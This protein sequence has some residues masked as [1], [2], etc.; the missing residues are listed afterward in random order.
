M[1]SEKML[2]GVQSEQANTLRVR[3]WIEYERIAPASRAK[4]LK[5]INTV[6]KKKVL[7]GGEILRTI[8][9]IEALRSIEER[10]RKQERQTREVTPK[11]MLHLPVTSNEPK[12]KDIG[13]Y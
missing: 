9:K 11:S 4:F 2:H 1:E 5:D 7:S 12:G 3:A 6:C 8:M 10:E 13:M